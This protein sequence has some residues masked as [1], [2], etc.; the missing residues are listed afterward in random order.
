MV[1]N[2]LHRCMGRWLRE[3]PGDD[4]DGGS[5]GGERRPS[6]AEIN[7]AR[8]RERLNRINEIARGQDGRRSREL[9]DV[10]GDHVVGRFQG[11][12]FDDTPEAREQK[13]READDLAQQALDEQAE[14]EAEFERRQQEE[15]RELQGEGGLEPG[16][17]GETRPR[18]RQGS[19]V[20]GAVDEKVV[21]G[22]RYYRTM[23]SGEEKWLT[24][25]E[26]REGVSRGLTTEDTLRRAQE[27]LASAS[28]SR[29]SPKPSADEDPAGGLPDDK[30]LENIIL[31]A[32]MG[33]EEAVKKLVSVIK[34]PAAGVKTTDVDRLVSQRI[35]TQRA[36]DRAESAQADLL[37]NETL[38]PVFKM[39]LA[40]YA[41]KNPN[42][43]IEEAYN[44]V[45][46][47]MRRDFAAMIPRESGRPPGPKDKA[48]RKREIVNPPRGVGR[49]PARQDD[50]REV[51]VSEQIDAI[52]KSRGQ[53]RAHRIRRS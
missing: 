32:S 2:F 48:L 8:N 7:A 1:H 33:D 15:A 45:G 35:A 38:A 46:S 3:Q 24:L 25:K 9:V 41:Q 19:A 18:G 42:T 20:D 47:Q 39:R 37:G 50:D 6:P 44:Q 4:G 10:D 5:G 40:A 26:L 30:D 27:A 43:R 14:R 22:V 53:S 29:E 11:G 52:A 21:D 17:E 34:R 28:Q 51:P 16:D 31:S 49:Q 12:E 23:V 36:V 13:A